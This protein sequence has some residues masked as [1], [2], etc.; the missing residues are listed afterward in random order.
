MSGEVENSGEVFIQTV[1]NLIKLLAQVVAKCNP[2]SQQ[3]FK[4]VSD[5]ST[6]TAN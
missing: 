4:R 5:S 3:L 1:N 2:L 6:E